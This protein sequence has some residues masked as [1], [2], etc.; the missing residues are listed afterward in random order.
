VYRLYNVKT[1]N[2]KERTVGYFSEL[3]GEVEELLFRGVATADIA[4]HLNMSVEQVEAYIQQLEDADRKPPEPTEYEEWQ[5]LP[6]GGDDAF[7][8]CNHWEDC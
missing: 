3:A 8:T 7:E 4:E 6:W 2:N 5:D 1:V